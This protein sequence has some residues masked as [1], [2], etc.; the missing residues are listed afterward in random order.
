M[1]ATCSKTSGEKNN[2]ESGNTETESSH[3]P[4]IFFVFVKTMILSF[5]LLVIKHCKNDALDQH[6]LQRE[7]SCLWNF[8]LAVKLPTLQTRSHSGGRFL[9]QIKYTPDLTWVELQLTCFV[10][11]YMASHCDKV[12]SIQ[13]VKISPLLP[14]QIM[15]KWLSPSIW[16]T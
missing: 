7:N 14:F 9:Q 1:A 2:Y 15:K 10:R 4:M 16:M 5:S 6:A 12:L 13:R 11:P 3:N 8:S